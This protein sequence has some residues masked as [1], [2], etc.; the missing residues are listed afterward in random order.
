MARLPSSRLPKLTQ[1]GGFERGDD[2]SIDPM[3]LDERAALL[4]EINVDSVAEQPI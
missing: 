2:M 1:P 4:G 3:L